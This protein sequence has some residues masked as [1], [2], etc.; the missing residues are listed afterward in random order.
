MKK[1]QILRRPAVIKKAEKVF[2]I[3]KESGLH[4]TPYYVFGNGFQRKSMFFYL[5]D[6]KFHW[7]DHILNIIYDRTWSQ[8]SL[9]FKPQKPGTACFLIDSRTNL[10]PKITVVSERI[11]KETD[12]KTDIW[13]C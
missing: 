3:I 2:G 6:K 13:F 1:I 11:K 5:S 12:L 7:W 4:I 9:S 8:T 10:L